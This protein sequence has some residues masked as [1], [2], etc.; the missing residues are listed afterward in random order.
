MGTYYI[1]TRKIFGADHTMIHRNR[2]LQMREMQNEINYATVR[3]EE[4]RLEVQ[5]HQTNL[6]RWIDNVQHWEQYLESLKRQAAGYPN[7]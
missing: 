4:S 5:R 3:L 6:D 2:E 7:G 1:D